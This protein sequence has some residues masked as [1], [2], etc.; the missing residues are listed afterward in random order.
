MAQ[1]QG[2]VEVVLQLRVCFLAS[3]F[4]ELFDIWVDL[5]YFVCK[6]GIRFGIG[7]YFMDLVGVLGIKGT[8][9]DKDFGI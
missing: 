7:Q 1:E 5:E 2:A 9:G 6:V 4:V 8:Y 3:P